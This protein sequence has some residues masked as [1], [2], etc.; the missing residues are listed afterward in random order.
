MPVR[1]QNHLR[2]DA[3]LFDFHIQI[4]RFRNIIEAGINDY[5]FAGFVPGERAVF[6]ERVELKCQYLKHILEKSGAKIL[7]LSLSSLLS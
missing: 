5:A 2:L 4:Q 6:P 1:K 3:F 7:K